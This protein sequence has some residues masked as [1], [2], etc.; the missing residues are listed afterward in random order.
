MLNALIAIDHPDNAAIRR[1]MIEYEIVERDGEV[2]NGLKAGTTMR[3]N[4]ESVS[5]SQL[6]K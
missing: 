4:H 6:V 1:Y 2:F 3:V 5:I